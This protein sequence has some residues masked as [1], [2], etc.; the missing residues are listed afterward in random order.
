MN[1]TLYEK[2]LASGFGVIHFIV[3]A[4]EDQQ[5]KEAA[6][7]Y[8]LLLKADTW[9]V[10]I[11]SRSNV[12]CSPLV[13]RIRTFWL[14]E[15]K[16]TFSVRWPGLDR[17]RSTTAQN[18][19]RFT[20]S[21][22]LVRAHFPSQSHLILRCSSLAKRSLSVGNVQRAIRLMTA[23]LGFTSSSIVC[24]LNCMRNVSFFSCRRSRGWRGT[25]WRSWNK[26]AARR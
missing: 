13:L 14:V 3:D 1:K 24:E 25:A 7:A 18:A 16:W 11:G 4:S 2:T 5:F 6:L 8:G 15:F 20:S 9:Q 10:G 23:G 19:T 17:Q 12:H 26:D 21:I 22:D